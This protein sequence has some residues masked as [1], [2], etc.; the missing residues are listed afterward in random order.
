M[1]SLISHLSTR[2]KLLLLLAFPMLGVVGFATL[3]A[4]DKWTQRTEMRQVATRTHLSVLTS[5]VIHELQKERGMSAGFIGSQGKKFA[6]EL[7]TQRQESD[8]R[9]ADLRA[10]ARTSGLA[11]DLA[12]AEGQLA[13]LA[14]TRTA[15][16]QLKL[17]GKAS[18]D[19][20]TATIESL[21]GVI[22]G[23]IRATNEA[24]IGRDLVAYQAFLRG[25]EY[26]GRERATVNGAL[27]ANLFEAEAYR[28]FLN[29]IAAQDLHFREFAELGEADIVSRHQD[30]LKNPDAVEVARIRQIA[31]DQS[32]TG[33]FGIEPAHWFAVITRKIDAMKGVENQLSERLVAEAGK[34]EQDATV[35][36][37]GLAG[38]TAAALLLTLLTAW[39]VI[40]GIGRELGGEPALAAAIA[41]Q[42]AEGDLET[43]IPTR[44]GDRSSLL[45]ALRVMVERLSGI[46]A[47][48]QETAQ[49]LGAAATEV[50][51]T[52]QTFS[53]AAADQAVGV[54][55]ASDSVE[56]MSSSISQNTRNARSTDGIARQVASQADEGAQA[57][58]KTVAAMKQIAD[59]IGIIDDI[60]Y[61]TNLLALNAAIEA[62]RAGEHGK[63]FAVVAAEVRKLAERSQIAAGEIGQLASGSV[64]TAE[65]AGKLLDDILP[66]I[67]QTAVLVQEIANASEAQASGTGLITSAMRQLS[68]STQGNA[69]T[70]G[71][72][73]ATAE[74]MSSQ[75]MQLREM[76]TYFRLDSRIVNNQADN[77]PPRSN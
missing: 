22:A 73:S 17:P 33:A 70:S 68:A 45:F 21:L 12:R 1:F 9:L 39:L 61:Q 23:S 29:L 26:A 47:Q 11:A 8:R 7:P 41:R 38:A 76:V 55:N 19:Y 10:D 51:D 35:A 50:S 43:A 49:F 54:K 58:S 32:A 27:A 74:E 72:L 40:R 53:R 6:S 31:I 75:S 46:I 59:K 28:R 4:V 24:A 14:E 67:K 3:L 62:A 34:L 5:A 63:G 25:K 60:A 44:P 77:L 16:S 57:V 37:W 66:A 71:E 2:A 42:V 64:T 48:I 52:A 15:I 69:T 13:R 20:Y 56:Q 18:F 36:L 65:H 30:N